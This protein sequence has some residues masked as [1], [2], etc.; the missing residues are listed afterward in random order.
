VGYKESQALRAAHLDN[1]TLLDA[2][3]A[4]Y[5]PLLKEAIAKIQVKTEEELR[6]QSI[7]INSKT[8]YLQRSKIA[9][10]NSLKECPDR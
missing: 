3:Q 9:Y 1:E 6:D 7:V 8:V 4:K 2:L 5:V 10:T